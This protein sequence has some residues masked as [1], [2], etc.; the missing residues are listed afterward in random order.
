MDIVDVVLGLTK[1]ICEFCVVHVKFYEDF[2]SAGAGGSL[3]A[4]CPPE[5]RH[6]RGEEIQKSGHCGPFARRRDRLS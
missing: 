5:C 6:C 2:S 4:L 1:K 3:R